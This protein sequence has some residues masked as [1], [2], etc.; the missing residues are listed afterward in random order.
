MNRQGQVQIIEDTRAPNQGLSPDLIK[1]IEQWS[2]RSKLVIPILIPS[3]AA[4]PSNN[5]WRL[6]VVQ[7]CAHIRQW[8]PIEI[9]LLTQL[10]AQVAIAIQQS[11]LYQQVQQFN[12]ALEAEVRERT[13]QLQQAF[14]FEAT[15]KHITDQVRD[16]LD[17]AQIL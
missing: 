3:T 9:E 8:Q 1:I 5:L 10:A 15:L 16:H 11:E 14:E 2:V 12:I 4:Q 17:E 6:L 7:Q 13:Y